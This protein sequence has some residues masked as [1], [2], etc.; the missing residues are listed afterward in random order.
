MPFSPYIVDKNPTEI[1]YM[2]IMGDSLSDRAT[3]YGKTLFWCIPMKKMA[4]LEKYSPAGRFTN[5]LVWGDHVTAAIASDFTIKRLEK[6]WHLS[7]TD[8]ADAVIVH[9]KRILDAV[10]DGYSLD[11]DKFV[12]FHGKLWVRSYCEGG[13]MSHDYSWKPSTS[14]KRFF[15]RMILSPLADM[16]KKL[17]EYDKQHR[18]SYKEKRETLI[19]EWSGANDLITVNARPSIAEVDRAIAARVVNVKKLIQSGYRHFVLFNLPNLA[20]TPRFQARTEKER[21][22]AERCS[23]YFN[24]QLQQAC[25]QLS[26]EYPYCSIDLF[27]INTDFEE[28][29]Y[30]PEQYYF[31]KN[32]QTKSYIDSPDFKAPKNGISASKGYMFYDDLHPSADMH[33]LLAYKFYAHLDKRYILLEPDKRIVNPIPECTVDELLNCFRIHY[34]NALEHKRHGFFNHLRPSKFDYWNVSLTTIL[35]HAF[36]EDGKLI[37]KVLIELGWISDQGELILDSCHLER[38]MNDLRLTSCLK[39][40]PV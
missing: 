12:N 1:K 35:Q 17:L 9:D 30:H 2:V 33:A 37:R 23:C 18:V 11:D 40:M 5:G 25:M 19:I 8:I 3:I 22:E 26:R 16:R 24:A 20:L 38:A 28:I 13:L 4:G 7:D 29:Y 10:Y 36:G 34:K 31:D 39:P 6:K 15:S 21:Q 14:I 32:K 27:D